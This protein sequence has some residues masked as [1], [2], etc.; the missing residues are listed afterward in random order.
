MS[1]T[2]VKTIKTED[3]EINV[4]QDADGYHAERWSESRQMITAQS[5]DWDAMQDAIDAVN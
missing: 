5:G 3:G 1:S 4:Y 2:L